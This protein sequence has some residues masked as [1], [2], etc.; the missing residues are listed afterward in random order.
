MM[1]EVQLNVSPLCTLNCGVNTSSTALPN[2]IVIANG[3]RRY[4]AVAADALNSTKGMIIGGP[5]HQMTLTIKHGKND[6]ANVLA[7]NDVG[8][9]DK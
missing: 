3:G 2:P 9:N 6:L 8:I 4:N 1:I 5:I 7:R